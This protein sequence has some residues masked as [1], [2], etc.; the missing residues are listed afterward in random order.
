MRM[1]RVDGGTEALWGADSSP[2]RQ[3]ENPGSVPLDLGHDNHWITTE[4]ETG[5]ALQVYILM[6]PAMRI[7][8]GVVLPGLVP[9]CEDP[10]F[11]PFG[12]RHCPH[13]GCAP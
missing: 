8:I 5:A 1:P 12:L 10:Q 3:N 9:G 7:V 4:K 6:P 2:P 11:F 13:R